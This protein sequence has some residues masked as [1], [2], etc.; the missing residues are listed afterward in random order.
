[1]VTSQRILYGYFASLYNV[2]T[3]SRTTRTFV[4][5]A[6]VPRLGWATLSQTIDTDN[7]RSAGVTHPNRHSYLVAFFLLHNV[8]I[9]NTM[10]TAQSHWA[11]HLRP[12]GAGDTS[13]VFQRLKAHATPT[14]SF[15]NLPRE[16]RDEIY[17]H[18][19]PDTLSFT[20]PNQTREQQHYAGGGLQ[21]EHF[22]LHHYLA[23]DPV[24]LTCRQIRKEMLETIYANTT[25]CFNWRRRANFILRCLEAIPASA[26]AN[27]RHLSWTEWALHT[28][29]DAR[30]YNNW[31][32][33]MRHVVTHFTSLRT[34][35]WRF[36]S[37]EDG[38]HHYHNWEVPRLAA[39]MLMDGKIQKLSWCWSY[40]TGYH[41]RWH[42]DVA[43]L[44]AMRLLCI[45]YD[46]ERDGD[47]GFE[48]RRL[49]KWDGELMES[50][51][52]DRWA[53]ECL[54]RPA[55]QFDVTIGSETLIL[56][57]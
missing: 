34:I 56:T 49:L 19:V 23:A 28:G 1:M 4:A 51:P 6:T 10:D 55:H 21:T 17:I 9:P 3:A 30:S 27:I 54:K 25:F 36:P 35:H 43:I 46:E 11:P 39:Q 2:T 26:K 32:K 20:M 52:L 31:A 8:D 42:D 41:S 12:N 45:P 7:S 13:V 33:V 14:L 29:G 24:L 47:K 57:R 5:Y 38:W 53:L 40:L 44:T 15:L 16:L 48:F 37:G 50:D 18:L 22:P